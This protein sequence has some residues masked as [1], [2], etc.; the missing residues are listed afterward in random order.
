MA[1]K[2]PARKGA[3]SST[4]GFTD[5]ERAA[6]R[7]AVRERRVRSRGGPEDGEREVL[8]KIAAMQG[9]DRVIARRLH[10]IIKAHA[11]G[12][13]P[14]TWYGMP[15]Y[16]RNGQPKFPAESWSSTDRRPRFRN[17]PDAYLHSGPL[18][19]VP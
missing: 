18:Y 3:P 15:A 10:A 9:S 7:E 4:S 12:L 16:G 5:E 6:M 11:P 8:A 2:K 13:S 14:R 17:P 19:N 1:E